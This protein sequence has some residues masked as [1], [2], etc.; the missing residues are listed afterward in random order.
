M[1]FI[2]NIAS[3]SMATKEQNAIEQDVP[4]ETIAQQ[5]VPNTNEIIDKLCSDEFSGR[6]VGSEGN[7]KTANYI[8][9]IFEDIGL[10]PLNGEFYYKPYEQEVYKKYGLVDDN[11][12]GE[13]KTIN[14][15]V[16][17]IKGTDSKKAIV[18]SA[19]F[20]HVGYQDG[21]IIRG[22]L[23]NASGVAALI[24]IADILNNKSKN[25]T[26]SRDIIIASFNGE[27]TGQEGSKAFV[28]D[29]KDKYSNLYNINIDCVGGKKAGDIS[30]NNKSKVSDKLTAEMKKTFT[31]NEM[32][33][34]DKILKGATSDHKSFEDGGIPNIYIG[35]DNLKPY[36]HN[37][38]DNPDSLNCDE[39][40]KV[41]KTICDFIEKN[42][43]HD[44]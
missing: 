26:F 4:K 16:G 5:E 14:N 13:N 25:N 17:V 18:I 24:K 34:S 15:V 36:T 39:I 20:D 8:S 32:K 11:D 1:I 40:N 31:D 27:E 42:H 43:E 2:L 23:D 29:I 6:L 35:Q 37:F 7:E 3:C 30:L 44:F 33:F 10:K 21:K 19:H 38:D 28:D 9:K 22:A 12:N 41:V